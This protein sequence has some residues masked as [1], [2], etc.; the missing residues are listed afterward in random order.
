M[1]TL[2]IAS[3]SFTYRRAIRHGENGYIAKA[4]E[5]ASA[6]LQAVDR[7]AESYEV[8]ATEARRDALQKFGWQHQTEAILNALQIA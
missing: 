1:G 3:P 2:S 4:H 7:S 5:W 8:M 6:I